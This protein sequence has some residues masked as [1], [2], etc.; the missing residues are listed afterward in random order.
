[1][2]ALASTKAFSKTF[3]TKSYYQNERTAKSESGFG[4]LI[5]FRKL[6]NRTVIKHSTT[7]VYIRKNISTLK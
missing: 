2:F 5:P 3:A 4:L 6:A 1:M 7:T